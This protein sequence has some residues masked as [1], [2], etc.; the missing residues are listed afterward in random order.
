M[1][2]KKKRRN[3]AT[4]RIRPPVKTHGG[5]YFLAPFITEHFPE[6]YEEL[7][8]CEPFCAGASVFFNKKRSK[9]EV[10]SDVDEGMV[11]VLKALR[12]EPQ[13]FISRL[14]RTKYTERTFKM[15]LNRDKKGFDDYVD[16]AINEFILRRMSRGGLKK[17]FAWSDRERGGQPGDVNAWQTIL[18]QLNALSERLQGVTILCASF[19]EVIPTWDEE[20][21]L[22]YLDPPYLHSTR[23]EGATNLYEK[24]LTVE[25]H[26][27]MLNLAKNARGKVVISGYPSP[28]YN[29]TLKNW[30]CKKKNVANHSSQAKTKERRIECLWLNY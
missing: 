14:K 17:A 4:K 10:L 19:A 26:I 11:M 3:M 28:L 27:H 23:A 25:E 6:N 22:M 7:I 30:R 21:T 29:R 15:A 1:E 13:E 2:I 9:E 5:K 12:D 16:H 8:Y 24:E 20:N 18:D